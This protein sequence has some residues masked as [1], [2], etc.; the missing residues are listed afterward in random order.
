MIQNLLAFY[1][2]W[3]EELKMIMLSSSVQI[4]VQKKTNIIVD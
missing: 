4:I 2:K 1:V 3:E